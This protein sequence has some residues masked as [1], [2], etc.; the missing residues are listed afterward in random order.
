MATKD[1]LNNERDLNQAKAEGNKY[2]KAEA[3][4]AAERVD[5]TRQLNAD[6]KDQLGVRQKLTDQETALR[7][8]GKDVVDF[9]RKNV[10][11]LGN[12]GKI[13]KNIADAQIKQNQL[14]TERQSL[15]NSIGGDSS[16]LV[17]YANELADLLNEQQLKGEANQRLTNE[18]VPVTAKIEEFNKQINDAKSD[19]RDLTK[20][21]HDLEA[22]L[23][24]LTG[25][26][27][28]AQQ[29]KI[30]AQKDSISVSN[31]AIK[32]LEDQ[33]A[34]Q[35]ALQA[36]KQDTLD[37]AKKELGAAESS[38]DRIRKQVGLSNMIDAT[39]ATR[40]ATV[41]ALSDAHD[42]TLG[43]M[44]DEDQIQSEINDKVGVTGAIVEGVGGIMQRLGMRS[45]IFDDA[46]KG[47]KATMD[48]MAEKSTR[49]LR[50]ELDEAGNKI[51]LAS[52]SKDFKYITPETR[53]I[54]NIIN[55]ISVAMGINIEIQKEFIINTVL[56]SIKETVESESDY[57]S[58]VR[59]M[60]EKGKKI[61]SYKDFYNT[62][63][64]YYTLGTF[65]I[66]VQTSIPSVKTRKTHPGCIRSFTGYP[67]EGQG[68]LS[69]LTYL[70]N[71]SP[72]DKLPL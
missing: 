12:Q 20:E 22:G 31:N 5:F 72:L 49:V 29:K 9:A 60:A 19:Q 38:I 24:G 52:A 61:M 33:L 17:G 36:A 13:Q 69:S 23:E 43:K 11:E 30:Q 40:L 70:L 71:D 25:K 18:L 7:D 55:A 14:T 3:Q 54:S 35:L 15:I 42:V 47:A 57:K 39:T 64:L 28:S 68:D 1:E 27:L 37:I 63:I 10:V 8:L 65:L 41:L 4:A 46:M 16:K 62:A 44:M 56:D 67:F 34:P 66:S 50:Y 53:M 6:L 21:L 51:M 48:A 59:E 26:Q 2:S 58:K 45:G 32:S